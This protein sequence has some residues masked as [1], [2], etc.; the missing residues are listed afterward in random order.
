MSNLPTLSIS[1]AAVVILLVLTI[2]SNDS[3]VASRLN[4]DGKNLLQF[5]PEEYTQAELEFHSYSIHSEQDGNLVNTHLLGL[6][7]DRF[8]YIASVGDEVIAVAVP[9]TTDDGFN[10]S[11]DLLVSIDMFGRIQ[12]A[13]VLEDLES[14]EDH[15]VV[16]VIQSRWMAG[17]SGSSMR[18]IQRLSWQ[19]LRMLMSTINSL[20]L[21]LHREPL[22]IAYMM[23]WYFFRLIELNLSTPCNE[24]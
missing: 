19:P 4:F 18:D 21:Q 23:C 13:R 22:Q 9:A 14:N 17:F 20:V 10:G 15:G 1:F 16:D 7:R 5:F 2:I 24:F 6:V 12:A 3:V 8:A 11:I